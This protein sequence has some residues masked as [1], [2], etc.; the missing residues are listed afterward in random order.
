MT[1]TR[2]QKTEVAAKVAKSQ[3]K[4]GGKLL[5]VDLLA[6]ISHQYSSRGR[7]NLVRSAGYASFFRST[8][9]VSRCHLGCYQELVI[10]AG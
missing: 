3:P 9:I 7:R 8:E 4:L 2:A 10:R 6:R 5:V 1:P